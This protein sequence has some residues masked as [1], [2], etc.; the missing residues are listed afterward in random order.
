MNSF[1]KIFRVSIFGES[2]GNELGIVIDGCPPGIYFTEEDLYLDLTRRKSGIK[3]TTSR[4]ESDE[5]KIISGIYEGYTTGAP[6]AIIFEN[7]NTNSSDYSLFR[8][9]P[10]PGHADFVAMKKWKN[11]NDHRGGGHF[12][13]RLTLGLVSAGVL[14]KKII[15]PMKVAARL[16]EAGGNSDIKNAIDEAVVEND[17]IGGIVKCVTTSM[18]IG[19]GEPFFDSIESL[20]SHIVFSVPAIKGIEF[21]SG[22][23]A[24]KMTGYEHNDKYISVD[25]IT[26][27]NNSGGVNGGISNGNDLV[28]RVAIKPTSSIPKRQHTMNMQTSQI[29]DL[30]IKGR[31]DLCVA[32]RIPPIIESVTAIVLA[33]LKMIYQSYK[34]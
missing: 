5:P 33:D 23:K 30:D 1:G 26:K 3:G 9:V 8:E 6:I 22:F 19:L 11:F 24:A 21:G 10:R 4:Q 2:H 15:T 17:S 13:G 16:L 25:G 32:L 14:A 12:S 27:T 18:P 20:L 29:V 31:H 28:Y 34:E 7:N